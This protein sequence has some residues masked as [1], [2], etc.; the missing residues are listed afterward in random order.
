[1]VIFGLAKMQRAVPETSAFVQNSVAEY[2]VWKVWYGD[3]E[4]PGSLM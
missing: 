2:A 4:E 3:D 1:M